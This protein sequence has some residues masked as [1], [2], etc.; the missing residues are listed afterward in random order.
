MT[1]LFD[2]LK[3][4]KTEKTQRRRDGEFFTPLPFADSRG[5]KI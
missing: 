5:S 2:A 4:S 3:N 1:E